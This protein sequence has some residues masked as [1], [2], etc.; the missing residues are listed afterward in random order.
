MY[1]NNSDYSSN[2]K[3]GANESRKTKLKKGKNKF[4][5]TSHPYMK[6]QSSFQSRCRSDM[7]FNWKSGARMSP[8]SKDNFNPM[9]NKHQTEANSMSWKAGAGDYSNK[10]K[11]FMK[12]SLPP[13]ILKT[14]QCFYK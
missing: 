10:V 9:S 3:A 6:D 5:I 2:Q 12:N 8:T 7:K 11:P 14:A 4:L 13:V 1:S